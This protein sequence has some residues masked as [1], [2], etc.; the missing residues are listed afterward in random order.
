MSRQTIIKIWVTLNLLA[1]AV[2]MVFAVSHDSAT[3]DEPPHLLSGYVALRYGHDYIDIEH[4]LLAKMYAATPLL[5]QDIKINLSDPNYNIQRK[6]LEVGQMF[7][8]SRDF[9]YYGTNNP[10]SILFTSRIPMIILTAVFGFVVFLFTKKLFGDLAG[11][12]AVFLYSTESVILSNGSLFNTDMPANGFILLTIFALLLYSHK[13]SGKR[14]LFLIL[15]LLAALL[16]KFST[17]YLLPIIVVSMELIYRS[18]DYR[19]RKHIAYLLGGVLLSIPIFYGLVSFRDRGLAGF[20]PERYIEGATRVFFSVSE[21]G[22]PSYLLGQNY[23]GGRWY[24]FP[25]LVL[26]KTQILT[27]LGVVVSLVLFFLKKIK[28]HGKALLITVLPV[29]LFFFLAVLSKFNIGVRHVL[30]IYP[31][32]II[33]AAGGFA[34]V[35]RLLINNFKGRLGLAF[36]GLVILIIFGGRVWST[37]ATY[38]H[39][40]SYFNFTVGGTNNGWKV[41]DDA[42]YDWGQDV[43][44]LTDFVRINNIKSIGFDN[45]TGLYAA[46]DYYKLPVFQFL[47]TDKNY[48]GYVALS[49]SVIDTHQGTPNSYSWIV[50]NYKPVAKA[51]KSIFIYKLE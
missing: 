36:S 1:M 39:F 44:R 6:N 2:L 3:S 19:P 4:P 45:F 40:L 35:I 37:A 25:V 50:D 31:F 12:I 47:P 29:A 23:L 15:S 48:K 43:K 42:N 10:D 17:L 49:T 13:Q 38:P 22:R 33:F 27:L 24:Y 51:G 26:T 18:Q 16:S 7:T 8:A 21:T 5:F 32:L 46:R 20:F 28:L 41:A 9:L 14:L 30:P 11:I 34:A